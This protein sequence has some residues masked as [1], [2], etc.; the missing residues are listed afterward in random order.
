M[1]SGANSV[2]TTPNS[3]PEN[4]NSVPATHGNSSSGVT[5][6]IPQV[7]QGYQAWPYSFYPYGH[8]LYMPQG[9][10]QQDVVQATGFNPGAQTITCYPS[11]QTQ[12]TISTVGSNIN[13]TTNTES[14]V[15]QR[16]T[17]QRQD[18]GVSPQIQ[19]QDSSQGVQ[20]QAFAPPHTSQRGMASLLV[21]WILLAAI[22][23]LVIRRIFILS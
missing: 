14:S 16:L 12:P 8:P 15:R 11:T 23:A 6:Q 9:F 20:P 5:D 1:P 21:I 4:E 17:H 7:A 18:Q 22:T 13:N 2:E 10:G 3:Q 19:N